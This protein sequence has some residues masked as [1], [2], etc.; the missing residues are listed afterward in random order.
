MAR[1]VLTSPG[2]AVRSVP[3]IKRITSVGRGAEVDVRLED[4]GA[5]ELA[6]TLLWDGRSYRAGSVGAPFLVEGKKRE[7]HVLRDGDVI[8]VADTWIA[9]S[10]SDAPADAEPRTDPGREALSTLKRLTD[11]SARLLHSGDLTTLLEALLDEAIDLTR[12][13]RGFLVL[14]DGDQRS[15]RVARNVNRENVARDVETLS[16]TVVDRVLRTGEPLLVSDAT[17][18]PEFSAST[19]VVN[20]K[21]SSVL[22]VPLMHRGRPFGVVY[23]GTDRVGTHFDRHGLDTLTIFAAQASLLVQNALLLDELRADNRG[24]R[25]RLEQQ[26]FGDLLGSCPGMQEVYRQIEKVAP[27]DLSV[28]VVGETGTGKELVARELHRRSPRA[29]GPFVAINCG[30]LPETLLES[31]LF[32]HVKGA[33]TGA[34]ATRPGRFQQASGG[35]LFL[36]EVGDM[37]PVLQVKLLRALQD[38]TVQKVG[39]HRDEPVDIRVIAATHRTLEQEVKRGGF[40]EDL[41]YRLATLTL[42]VPPLRD[43]GEDVA[44]L[45]RGFLQTFA[46]SYRATARGFTPAALAAVRRHSW[47]GNVRELENRIKKAVVLSDGPLVRAEDLDFPPEDLPPLTPLQEAKDDFERRYVLE[48]LKRHGGNRA[49]TARALGVD[50]RTIFRLLER[51]EG[52]PPDR[53]EEPG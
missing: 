10:L 50:P 35:T 11:F 19:S 34:V 28:L 25:A 12:G 31:E 53:E 48:A 52:V 14:V 36:D 22:C 51:M 17:A 47:P 24:L 33:F 6:L 46:E 13:D 8:R 45:A 21:L 18:D 20:L 23:V 40:R 26:R 43:R 7:A 9:L 41:Y 32:G 1:L 5:P 37:P 44:V 4:A 27:T 49:R 42:R 38:R 2:G 29:G 30:A 16:D 15:V 39:D 3:L